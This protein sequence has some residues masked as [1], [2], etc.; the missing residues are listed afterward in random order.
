MSKT[1]KLSVMDM[2]CGGCEK[3][4]TE[5]LMAEEGVITVNANHA[6]DEVEIVFDEAI[7]EE[8][9]LLDCIEAAGFS[10]AD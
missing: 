1:V 2:K 3:T 5:K 8:D 9:D 6:T 7:I 4:V 10:V